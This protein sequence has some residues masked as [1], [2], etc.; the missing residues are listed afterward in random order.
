MAH[1]LDRFCPEQSSL[2]RPE[3]GIKGLILNIFR[4]Y[5]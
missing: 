5:G 2:L 3:S 1:E 4:K